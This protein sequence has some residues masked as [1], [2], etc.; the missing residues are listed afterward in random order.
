MQRGLLGALS[1]CVARVAAGSLA[2]GLVLTA[3][4]HA[5]PDPA[6]GDRPPARLRIEVTHS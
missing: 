2:T 4:T 6:M 1:E 5:P 3:C